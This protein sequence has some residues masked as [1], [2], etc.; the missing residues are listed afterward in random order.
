MTAASAET[1]TPRDGL[2]FRNVRIVVLLI[3]SNA[4]GATSSLKSKGALSSSREIEVA[5]VAD[6]RPLAFATS[7]A[8]RRLASKRNQDARSQHSRSRQVNSADLGAN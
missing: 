2:F 4:F 7:R 3:E 1:H 6:W 8:S 5:S